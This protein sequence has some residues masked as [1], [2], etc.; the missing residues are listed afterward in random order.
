MFHV[1]LY[2]TV[3]SVQCSLV[4]TCLERADLLALLCVFVTFQYGVSGQVWYLIV[5]IP[6]LCILLYFYKNMRQGL[7]TYASERHFSIISSII[8]FIFLEDRETF[9]CH[10]SPELV[11]R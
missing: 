2:Y 6:A 10:Q 4:V 3:L 1:C 5:S 11:T 8:V 7:A 9:A